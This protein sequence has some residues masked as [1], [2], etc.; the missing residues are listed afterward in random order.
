MWG[1]EGKGRRGRGLRVAP[2]GHH[3]QRGICGTANPFLVDLT[4][5]L[6]HTHDSSQIL[7]T[8][9]TSWRSD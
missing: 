9:C 3:L 5:I 7:K 2:R 8:P 6:I 4:F 1:W